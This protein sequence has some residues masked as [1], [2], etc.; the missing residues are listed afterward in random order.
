MTRPDPNTPGVPC[1]TVCDVAVFAW[2]LVP[3]RCPHGAQCTG[4]PRKVKCRKCAAF[5]RRQRKLVEL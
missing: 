4:D 2:P 3:H 1:C 5:K